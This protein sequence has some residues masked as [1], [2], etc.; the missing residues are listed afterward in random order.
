MEGQRREEDARGL[1]PKSW[2]FDVGL[3]VYTDGLHGGD[4]NPFDVPAGVARVIHGRVSAVLGIVLVAVLGAATYIVK[5][6]AVWVDELDSR[7]VPVD[8]DHR[9]DRT[10]RLHSAEEDALLLAVHA[11]VY[12]ARG[13]DVVEQDSATFGESLGKCLGPVAGLVSQVGAGVAWQSIAH[14]YRVVAREAKPYDTAPVV[15]DIQDLDAYLHRG[16]E[17]DPGVTFYYTHSLEYVTL[18][19]SF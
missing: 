4:D 6:L 12:V 8:V 10:A 17:R 14:I 5:T 2:Q 16:R 7:T 18:F 1:K 15:R 19:F 3:V 13:R 11:K 9:P